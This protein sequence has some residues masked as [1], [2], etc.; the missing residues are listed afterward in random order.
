M[1]VS[2]VAGVCVS[3][4]KT[5]EYCHLLVGCDYFNRKVQLRIHNFIFALISYRSIDRS[6]WLRV[7]T[8]GG[9]L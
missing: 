2:P 3:G 1:N 6:F 8:G 5:P 4:D 7:A 9:R